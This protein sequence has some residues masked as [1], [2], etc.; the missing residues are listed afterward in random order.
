MA[1]LIWSVVSDSAAQDHNISTQ[2]WSRPKPGQSCDTNYTLALEIF[3]YYLDLGY[4]AMSVLSKR[5][6]VCC[7]VGWIEGGGGL[8]V[9]Y[10]IVRFKRWESLRSRIG[11]LRTWRSKRSLFK[12]ILLLYHSRPMVLRKYISYLKNGYRFFCL[13]FMK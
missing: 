5:W 2:Q 12:D 11:S 7:L 4:L 13:S 9:S 3:G 8:F 1:V 6:D 10:I